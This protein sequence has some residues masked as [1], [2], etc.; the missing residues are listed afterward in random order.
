ML[1]CISADSPADTPCHARGRWTVDAG[2]G[3]HDP[4]SGKPVTRHAAKDRQ[5]DEQTNSIA[6]THDSPNENKSQGTFH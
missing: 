2:T 6:S 4:P 3:K 1:F 5:Q